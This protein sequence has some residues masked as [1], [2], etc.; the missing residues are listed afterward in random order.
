VIGRVE[1]CVQMGDYKLIE[2]L[3][4]GGLGQVWRARHVNF[5]ERDVALKVMRARHARDES[6]RAAFA[7]E[8]KAMAR[9]DHPGIVAILDAGAIEDVSESSAGRD[10]LGPYLVMEMANIGALSRHAMTFDLDGILALTFVTLDVLAHAHARGVIHRDIKP[11]NFLV[12]WSADE[13]PL[14]LT[15][16][17]LSNVRGEHDAAVGWGTPDYMAPEQLGGRWREQGPWTDL[18]AL[19]SMICEIV[20]GALPYGISKDAGIPQIDGVRVTREPLVDGFSDSLIAWLERMIARDPRARFPSAAEAAWTLAEAANLDAPLTWD[21]SRALL[22]RAIQSQPQGKSDGKA[23][24]AIAGAATTVTHTPSRENVEG[25]GAGLPHIKIA[26]PRWPERGVPKS[27]T[28]PPLSSRSPGINHLT[29]LRLTGREAEQEKLWRALENVAS[30]PFATP[31]I[32]LLTGARGLGK[33]QLA[34]WLAQQ[35]QKLGL[36]EHL[37]VRYSDPIGP[38]DGLLAAI[39]NHLGVQGLVGRNLLDALARSPACLAPAAGELCEQLAKL[40]DIRGDSPNHHRELSHLNRYEVISELF[41][42]T[43]A[44]K[45]LVVTVENVHLGAEILFFIRYLI[46][47][48]GLAMRVLF[49]LMP[50]EDE[51]HGRD[52][53]AALLSEVTSAPGVGRI[54]LEPFSP[55]EMRAHLEHNLPLTPELTKYLIEH[56]D[57]APVYAHELIDDLCAIGELERTAQGWGLRS[58][59]V[60]SR[61][62]IRRWVGRL[63]RFLEVD[64]SARLPLEVMAALGLESAREEWFLVCERLGAI[65]TPRL[66]EKMALFGLVRG[67]GELGLELASEALR[68][69][70]EQTSKREGRWRAINMCIASILSGDEP[71]R[72][73]AHHLAA[74]L[75]EAAVEDLLSAASRRLDRGELL[76]THALLD[77]LDQILE[78]LPEG[79]FLDLMRARISALRADC[80]DL[81]G[82]YLEARDVAASAAASAHTMG[83]TDIA[84]Q[85]LARHAFALLHGGATEEAHQRFGELLHDYGWRSPMASLAAREG[86]ARV[87]QRRGDIEQARQLFQECLE[88]ARELGFSHAE[89]VCHNGLGDIARQA[90]ELEVARGHS[91]RALELF[92]RRGHRVMVADC[93]NDLAELARLEGNYEEAMALCQRSISIFESVDSRLSHRARLELAYVSLGQRELERAR[94]LL[95]RLCLTFY[96]EKDFGQ[97][98]LAVV[99][100]LPVLAGRGEIERLGQAL[101]HARRLLERTERR[102]RDVAFALELAKHIDLSALSD[103]QREALRVLE[104]AHTPS[105]S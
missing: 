49:L 22:A 46:R 62:K 51:L 85:A 41:E 72:R 43:S 99:G 4:E 44:R 69:E 8:I 1:V 104:H 86:L 55:R 101:E 17:G 27:S 59:N 78:E 29:Q 9:V 13:S 76:R 97:L 60:I 71:E 91:A 19:G 12:G 105:S 7:N 81:Q 68:E 53:E 82:R 66:I 15:D 54:E 16:F 28:R 18:F 96:E 25:A 84:A 50:R 30:N 102:D 92:E 33:S 26:T 36:S 3:G 56:A 14:K 77:R 48:P 21:A 63:R 65:A 61:G 31:R 35:G 20:T 5:P 75:P 24:Q 2:L 95:E 89:A 70:L 90:N 11:A 23:I 74:D 37:A 42:H 79:G 88:E 73:G 93:L 58:E 10:L 103:S 32:M 34:G 52:L 40:L 38:F 94:V 98:A 57:G 80:F 47:R 67:D 64:P 39:A 83:L 87:A 6:K 45:P 100:M